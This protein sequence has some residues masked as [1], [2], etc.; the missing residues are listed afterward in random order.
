MLM[1]RASIT[2]LKPKE[3]IPCK[4]AQRRKKPIQSGSCLTVFRSSSCPGL[5]DAV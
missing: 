3:T 5:P 4:S 1:L 2:V